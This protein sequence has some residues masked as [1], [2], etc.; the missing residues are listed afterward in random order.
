[1]TWLADWSDGEDADFRAAAAEAGVPVRVVRSRPLG[2]SVGTRLHRARSW[3][4]YAALAAR[5]LAGARGGPVVAWQPLAGALAGLLRLGPRPPLVVLNPLLRPGPDG[6][7]MQRFA[8]AGLRRADHVVLFSRAAI[9]VAVDLGL[10]RERVSFV[11]LGVRARRQLPV[12]PGAALLA[13]G[14]D[15][16]D[17]PTL[18]A[19]ADGLGAEVWVVGPKAVA[20]PPNLRVLP[21]VDRAGFLDLLERSAALV[22]PIFPTGRSA[23]Q[24]AV[25]D[26]MSVGRAV[27]ATAGAGLEDYVSDETGRLVPPADPAALRAAMEQVLAP[28]AAA[29]L[30]AAALA[31]AHGPL[32]L[33]RFATAIA[34]VAKSVPST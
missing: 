12:P 8:L 5:G 33:T 28:G 9:P 32:S 17:W 10:A 11:P 7:R 13:A 21:P 30:G 1:M 3:P 20:G 18:A 26:A 31:R 4:A 19:A 27:V 15:E 34:A 16:R 24:L 6:G 25:L 22:V 14:R 2:V 29:S 23:G